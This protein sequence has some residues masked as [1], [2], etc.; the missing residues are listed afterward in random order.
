MNQ[1]DLKVVWICN[2]CN[3]VFIFRSDIDDHL[4]QSS[5]NNVHKFDLLSYQL[6]KR[7]GR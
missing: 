1:D 7:L 2:E 5:H 4:D 3:S 6:T